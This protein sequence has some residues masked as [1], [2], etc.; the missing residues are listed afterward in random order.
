MFYSLVKH[1]L[2]RVV[3]HAKQRPQWFEIRE[4]QNPIRFFLLKMVMYI[5]WM[6]LLDDL[7]YP[8]LIRLFIRLMNFR[9]CWPEKLY[10]RRKYP[11][12]TV[13]VNA[14]VVSFKTQK[15]DKLEM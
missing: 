1:G 14:A 10:G 9:G 12:L 4:P 2:R 13:R 15:I 3:Y 8:I 6:A 7:I 5:P 11:V